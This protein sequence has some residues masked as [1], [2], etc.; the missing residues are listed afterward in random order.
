[1]DVLPLNP[2]YPNRQYKTDAMERM[3]KNHYVEKTEITESSYGVFGTTENWAYV[4]GLVTAMTDEI[5]TNY[6]GKTS[7]V[8]NK[9]SSLSETPLEVI[10]E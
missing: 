6:F 1:M 9:C 3:D 8:F 5:L 2:F 10:Y 4:S 7:A